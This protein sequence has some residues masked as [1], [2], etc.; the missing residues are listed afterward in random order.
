LSLAASVLLVTFGSAAVI[1]SGTAGAAS[2]AGKS[3]VKHHTPYFLAPEQFAHSSNWL[4]P[5]GR[6]EESVPSG[7]H[8]GSALSQTAKSGTVSGGAA[9]LAATPKAIPT[10]VTF[11]VNTTSD[12][13]LKTDHST[14]CVTATTNCSLRAAIYAADNLGSTT[15]TPTAAT[16]D[17]PAGTFQLTRALTDHTGPLYLDNRAG[18]TVNGAGQGNT[19]IVGDGSHQ[20][21]GIGEGETTGSPALLENFTITGGTANYTTTYFEGCGGAV[22]QTGTLDVLQLTHV[23]LTGNTAVRG[24]AA[25]CADGAVYASNSTFSGNTVAPLPDTY[26]SFGGSVVIGWDDYGAARFIN[27]TIDNNTLDTSSDTTCYYTTLTIIGTVASPHVSHGKRVTTPAESTCDDFDYWFAAGGGIAAIYGSS[28]TLLNSQVTGN[29]VTSGSAAC[30]QTKLTDYCGFLAGGGVFNLYSNVTITG[31]T[32]NSN[33][34]NQTAD[35]GGTCQYGALGGGVANFGGAR[36]T[37]DHIDANR[38]VGSLPTVETNDTA[39]GGGV[40]SYSPMVIDTST[41]SYN[42]AIG[43]HFDICAQSG[44]GGIFSGSPGFVLRGTTVDHNSVTNGSVAGVAVW[45]PYSYTSTIPRVTPENPSNTETSPDIGDGYISGDSLANDNISYNSATTTYTYQTNPAFYDDGAGGGLLTEDGLVTITRVTVW[46]NSAATWAGGYWASSDTSVK[47]SNST[48]GDNTAYSGGGVMLT[49]YAFLTTLNT[50]IAGNS[51]TGTTPII[52]CA[53]AEAQSCL[54]AK[55]AAEPK[56]QTGYGPA[57]G[58]IY[59]AD[60]SL[61][62]LAY[63]TISGNTS[64]TTG[65]GLFEGRAVGRE[66][67]TTDE[68]GQGASTAVGTIIAGNTAAGVEQD[69][70]SHTTFNA[71]RKFELTDGGWNISGDNSCNLRNPT[72]QTTVTP[73]LSTLATHAGGIP[74]MV[75]Y[76]DS[77]AVGAGGGPACPLTDERGVSRPQD[78]RCDVGAVEVPAGYYMSSSTGA[79]YAFGGAPFYGSAHNGYPTGYPIAS[80]IV[81]MAVD[82]LGDGYWLVESNGAVLPFGT[83]GTYGNMARTALAAPIVGIVSSH[84]GNGYYLVSADG[85]VFAFGDA[86]FHGSAVALHLNKPVVGMAITPTGGGYRLVASDGGVFSYTAPFH[87]SMGG[88]HLNQPMVGI[89]SSPTGNGYWTVASDGGVFTFPSPT[90]PFFG[91]MGGQ[92]LNKPIVGMV[93][94]SNPGGYWMVGKD[95][96]VFAF[97]AATFVPTGSLPA[98]HITTDNVVG[99]AA[100]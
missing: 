80:P 19:K 58:G 14:S 72:D 97:G 34:V 23:T 39:E 69:C 9:P 73:R 6:V 55:G 86:P 42:A 22:W 28:L 45:S 18:V 90:L 29:T 56:G 85:G 98:L 63:D 31:S 53:T 13:T 68:F 50:T 51:S 92:T 25:L 96:G 1:A 33:S 11:V 76:V 61:V 100:A 24:G 43:T 35:C 64:A 87:G 5:G 38:V 66:Q 88:S 17:V 74:T 36:L 46:G 2:S 20:V 47:M 27:D 82:P 37:H 62:R 67:A 57:G 65:G 75:P 94:A 99:F 30:E 26:S 4:A 77:P 8:H 54:A 48:I 15:T 60:D 59:S 32:V 81:G 89:A 40:L 41:V 49:Y 71:N 84:D 95:G 12:E 83:A 70:A 10:G 7:R 21:L 16:I 93:A 79:V 3:Y 44:G 52:E 91:S 78:G